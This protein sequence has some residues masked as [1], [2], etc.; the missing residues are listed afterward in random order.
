MEIDW[1]ASQQAP[2]HS[3]RRFW[4]DY[5]PWPYS[6]ETKDSLV[7]AGRMC[8]SRNGSIRAIGTV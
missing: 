4:R 2:W 1:F 5:A 8:D 3:D 7:L 6:C